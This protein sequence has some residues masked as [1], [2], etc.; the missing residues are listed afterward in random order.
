MP[1]AEKKIME[2][3]SIRLRFAQVLRLNNNRQTAT[4]PQ[5]D[6]AGDDDSA[7]SSNSGQSSPD[8]SPMSRSDSPT[9]GDQPASISPNRPQNPFRCR[10]MSESGSPLKGNNFGLFVLVEQV[11]WS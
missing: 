6:I 10:S 11:G 3:D 2:I 1:I 5:T 8:E 7:Y 9:P 4:V